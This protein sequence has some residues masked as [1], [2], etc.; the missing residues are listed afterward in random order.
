MRL[1]Q[2]WGRREVQ[3]SWS[4]IIG[5]KHIVGELTMKEPRMNTGILWAGMNSSGS[6]SLPLDWSQKLTVPSNLKRGF[7]RGTT[8]VTTSGTTWMTTQK[9]CYIR[10]WF[11]GQLSYF[12]K[13]DKKW[14][15]IRGEIKLW[16]STFVRSE[17][18]RKKERLKG[19]EMSER[20]LGKNK[21]AIV[22]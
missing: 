5:T 9:H 22:S 14:G 7:W 11:G 19:A 17:L 2:N 18:S 20:V 4:Q 6:R 12:I 3:H 16:C 10:D 21:F 15:A 13:G 8:R 1:G